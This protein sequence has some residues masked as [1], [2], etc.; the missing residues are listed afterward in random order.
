[1]DWPISQLL[2]NLLEQLPV[3]I[4]LVVC[5]G[6]VVMR[7]KRSPKVSLL[8]LVG[9]VLIF[10]DGPIFLVIYA[11]AP[12]LITRSTS[13]GAATYYN[14]RTVLSVINYTVIAIAFA[15]LLAAIFIGREAR[16]EI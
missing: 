10:L 3:F 7:W 9:L 11:F 12:N 2:W 16:R 13:G 4:A 8:T 15:F 14:A 1:M 6:F 5:M